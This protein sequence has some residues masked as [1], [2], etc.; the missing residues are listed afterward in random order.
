MER[1]YRRRLP[2]W[3]IDD[4]WYY[5][6]FRLHGSI[7]A[8]QFER[9]QVALER[10]R[11]ALVRRYGQ[12]SA[13]L[14]RALAE[15]RQQAIEDYLDSQ[16]HVRYLAQPAAAEAYVTNLANGTRQLYQLG[17]WIVMP[18]HAHLLLKPQCD[19]RHEPIRLSRIMQH[20][21]GA[22]AVEINRALQRTGTFWQHES[23]DHVIRDAREFQRIA[24]YIENNPVKAGLCA[25]PE[26]W[27]W[28]SA[29]RL[30]ANNE[31]P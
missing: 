22:S 8:V 5:V 27:A 31:L 20:I 23:F 15:E 24:H 26:A 29:S 17:P 12:L 13:A 9:W 19:E 10:K 18:N 14:E 3:E 1:F 7:P 28:S 4:A 25:E 16:Y 11:Q 30:L 2:H 21:K 6:T